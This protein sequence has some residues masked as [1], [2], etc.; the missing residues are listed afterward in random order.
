MPTK[1]FY[2][3]DAVASGGTGPKLVESNTGITAADIGGYDLST[4][5]TSSARYAMFQYLAGGTNNVGFE[6]TGAS[7]SF[8]GIIGWAANTGPGYKGNDYMRTDVPYTGTFA[9][10]TWSFDMIFTNSGS[11]GSLFGY[12]RLWRS[13][14][15]NGSSPTS[16]AS[17]YAAVSSNTGGVTT[18]ISWT[19]SNSSFS[20]SNEY[21][22]FQWQL[23]TNAA[24]GTGRMTHRSST[25]AQ[26]T[27]SN[28]TAAGGGGLIIDPNAAF[29][30]ML[31][32]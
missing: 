28:F 20:L 32:R 25:T 3:S 30:H 2:V 8:N 13:V 26:I 24:S 4:A 11:I 9:A 7:T 31:I 21:L 23:S 10:G 6:E 16:I 19:W 14:N 12:V 18:L 17:P 5:S 15:A 27:T 1:S 22:F 29:R